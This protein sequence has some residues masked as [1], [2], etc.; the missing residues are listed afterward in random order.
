MIIVTGTGRSGTSVLAKILKRCG[1]NFRGDWSDKIR[2]G[3]EDPEIVSLNERMFKEYNLDIKSDF[4]NKKQIEELS[5]KYK[6]LLKSLSQKI[7]FAK[8]PRFCKTLEVWLKA[9]LDIDFLIISLRDK[10]ETLRSAMDYSPDS[11]GYKE[12]KEQIFRRLANLF[13]I[14]FEYGIDFQIVYFPNDYVVSLNHSLSP[15]FENISKKLHIDTEVI[16]NAIREEFKPE[17][18]KFSTISWPNNSSK[19]KFL[20]S[21][22]NFFKRKEYYENPRK[23]FLKF[24]SPKMEYI[25]DVGCAKGYLARAIKERNPNCKIF[26]IESN[27]SVATVANLYMDKVILGDVESVDL[28]EEG[29]EEKSFDCI[30]YGD[31]LEHLRDPWSVIYHHK[32]FLKDDGIIIASIPNIRNFEVLQ[33]LIDRGRW[34]YKEEGILDSDHTRFFTLRDIRHMF[35]LL[36]FDIIRILK[37]KK[38]ERDIN[39]E[40]FNLKNLDNNELEELST[41]QFVIVA[42]KKKI[43]TYLCS[44]IIP[45]FNKLEY[46]KR[47]IQNLYSVT[48]PNLFELIVVDNASTD[49]TKEYLEELSKQVDNLRF[50]RNRENLGFAK[51]CN[52]GA[53][54]AKGKYFVFL[55]NDTIPLEGWL[56]EMIRVIEEEENVGVVGSKL[57]FPDGTIQHAGVEVT[58]YP[59]PISP[60]HIYYRWPSESKEANIKREYPAVTGA[61]ML[62]PKQ[63]FDELGGFDEG[64]IN[65]YE[66]VDYCFRVKEKGYRII[67]NPKS[68]LY[69]YESVTEGRF[70]AVKE[71][72]ERL[73]KKWLGKIKPKPSSKISIVIL[74]YNNSEDTI[75]CIKSIYERLTY[76]RFQIILVD[77]GSSKEDLKKLQD[78]VERS[79]LLKEE[80]SFR[81]EL[82]FIRNEENLGFAAGNNIGIK[83][84]LKNG[85]DYIWILNNDTIIEKDALESSL[86]AIKQLASKK[87]GIVSSKIY[88]YEDKSKVQ[89][90]GDNVFYEGMEDKKDNPKIVGFAPACSLLISREVFEKAGLFNEDYFLYYED[91]D[92][93]K[94]TL[95]KRFNILYNPFS[96]VYHKGGAS[97]GRWL[98][99][100]TST[101]YATRNILYCYGNDM[102][103]DALTAIEKGYW[104]Y[105][106]KS[107]E[108]MKGVVEGAKDYILG[109]K[110]KVKDDQLNIEYW[111]DWPDER[112]RVAAK[113]LVRSCQNWLFIK[114][115]SIFKAI[116][117]KKRMAKEKKDQEIAKELCEK[118]EKEYSKGNIDKA[119]LIFEKAISFDRSCYLAYSNLAAIYWEMKDIEKA[120]Y[121]IEEAFKLAPDDPDVLWNYRQIKGICEANSMSV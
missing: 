69:H 5:N 48:D 38:K 112:L 76:R 28:K 65:G 17:N 52:Q 45:V 15:S 119:I 81:E 109:K 108:C 34:I 30:I 58:D 13:R 53:K 85:A 46:T 14:I 92:F 98:K 7:K 117:L 90:D 51:A 43:S 62:T 89:F 27:F 9:G 32:K 16:L 64:F 4:L 87:V 104:K 25:L 59:L 68:V 2:A 61:C 29:F 42:K 72:E 50:I 31:I 73:I 121:F 44:I 12:W 24:I 91:N 100:P 20:L 110:G 78:W 47:C 96:K 84:A 66:D 77:N 118:G 99:S 115:M 56:E 37:I 88:C 93:C 19:N 114:F 82:I 54:I 3:L 1:C 22:V 36:G 102:L 55:N 26:G 33:S 79:G 60:F 71:N 63:L 103:E 18:I 70:K 8:D 39:A 80:T 83:L 49:G 41:F 94:R 95:K 67:Y 21:P 35:S 23:E 120:I 10:E 116:V 101:Y 111:E 74:N 113:E 105:I 6:D 57:L 75:E 40:K 11:L 106:K 97:I 86:S 107:P